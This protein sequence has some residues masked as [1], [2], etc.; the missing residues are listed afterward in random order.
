VKTHVDRESLAIAMAVLPGIYSRNRY[1]SFYG[2]PEVRRARTRAAVL[3]GVVRHLLGSLGAVSDIVLARGERG[4]E[5]KYSVAAVHLE[6]TVA[7]SDLEAA[8]VA[9]LAS[10]AGVTSIHATDDDRAKIDGA[11]KRLAVGL[12]LSGIEA[13]EGGDV[14]LPSS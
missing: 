9:Y 13:G 6:R 8:C 14:S 1:F 3:R 7:L 5:L 10:R 2:D 11:L 4:C 12:R